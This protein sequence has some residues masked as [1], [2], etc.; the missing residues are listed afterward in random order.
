MTDIPRPRTP[1]A[2][3]GVFCVAA[4]AGVPCIRVRTR[5]LELH[6]DVNPAFPWGACVMV[7]VPPVM[8]P[9]AARLWLHA[10][11]NAPFSEPNRLEFQCGH[12]EL[13]VSG[14]TWWT[15]R[16]TS[17]DGRVILGDWMRGRPRWTDWPPLHVIWHSEPA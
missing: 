8:R 12:L 6:A 5:W 3:P 13:H 10:G 2:P 14:L 1:A 4:Y 7:N 15:F 11:L 17:R 16:E 9:R